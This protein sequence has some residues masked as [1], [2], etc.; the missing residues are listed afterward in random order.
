MPF[1]PSEAAQ[2]LENTVGIVP[3]ALLAIILLAGPTTA[4][5]LYHFVV[6]PR[7]S[8]YVA[9]EVD[10][11]WVC[12]DCRSANEIRSSRCYSCG[13]ERDEMVGDLRVVDEGGIVTLTAD[14]DV[15]PLPTP[16]TADR[17][18]VPVGPGRAR[19]AVEGPA[20]I[21]SAVPDD[22]GPAVTRRRTR[23]AVAAGRSPADAVPDTGE[24]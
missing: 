3:A 8:R 22:P 6:Q 18:L 12:E 21:R 9:S 23:T 7:T 2:W 20:A 10:L 4:W 11:L 24:E 15:V 16:A 1:D 17:P 13:L 14:D 5:L 19:E